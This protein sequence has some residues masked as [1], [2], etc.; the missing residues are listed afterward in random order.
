[1]GIYA[2]L[3][4]SETLGTR[5][6]LA[7]ALQMAESPPL[8]FHGPGVSSVKR[9]ESRLGPFELSIPEPGGAG[10]EDVSSQ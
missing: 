3:R 10:K 8:S 6:H 1:M 5:F 9:R 2:L 7:P 4:G